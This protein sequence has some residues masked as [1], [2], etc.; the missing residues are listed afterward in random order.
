MVLTFEIVL[1]LIIILVALVLFSFEWVSADVTAL[2]VLVTLILT[3]LLKPQEAFQ[4]FGSETVIMILGLLI[5]TAALLRTGVVDLAGR[6][7]LRHTGTNQF[8]LL[9]VIM[10]TSATLGAFMSNT[11]STAFFVPIVFGIA[12]RAKINASNLLMP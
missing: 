10:V 8:R 1:L 5:M 2:G 4:G 3:R 12:K 7:I 11:A 6:A 9:I